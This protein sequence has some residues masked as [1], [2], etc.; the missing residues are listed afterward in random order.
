VVQGVSVDA[1][2][3]AAHGRLVGWPEGAG[4][5]VAA[6]PECGQHLAG[7]VVGPLADLGKRSGAGQDRSDRDR[8]HG[9]KRVPSAS[10]VAW[11]G[12]LGEG[13]EQVRALLGCQRGGL[14]APMGNTRNGG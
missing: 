6:Y 12:D 2:Q 5:Q 13:V 7:R 10:S 8:Q 11:V 3:H 9:G 14:V 4:Q 1:G